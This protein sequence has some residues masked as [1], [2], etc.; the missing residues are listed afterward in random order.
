M[1]VSAQLGESVFFLCY[2][3]L[4]F[5]SVAVWVEAAVTGDTHFFLFFN[6]YFKALKMIVLDCIP[7]KRQTR[8]P[9]SQ[10]C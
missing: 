10:D 9:A 7:R 8:N 3:S 2:M 1:H 6:C 4:W 5:S